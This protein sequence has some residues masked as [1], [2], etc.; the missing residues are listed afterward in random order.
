MALATYWLTFLLSG[1]GLAATG[2][3]VQ[4]G[5]PGV[6]YAWQVLDIDTAQCLARAQLALEAQG[7]DPIQNDDTSIAGRSETVTAM[8]MCIENPPA[9]TTVMVVVAS[10]DDEQSIALREALKQAF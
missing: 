3:A 7:L 1:L 2:S 10:T 9:I 5:P 6:H 4:A 8:F